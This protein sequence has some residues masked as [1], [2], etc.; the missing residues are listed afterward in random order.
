M[1]VR[2]RRAASSR[3]ASP[4]PEIEAMITGCWLMFRALTCGLTPCGR[5]TVARFCSIAARVSLTSVPYENWATT[6]EI[7]PVMRVPLPPQRIA[8]GITGGIMRSE[9]ERP[10]LDAAADHRDDFGRVEGKVCG[11]RGRGAGVGPVLGA[12]KGEVG[13][14]EQPRQDGRAAG[15][16]HPGGG[17]QQALVRLL[18]EDAPMQRLAQLW[19]PR[20][21]AT[22]MRHFCVARIS[23]IAP[24]SCTACQL[25]AAGS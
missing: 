15:D 10:R 14:R 16:Q 2:A 8:T 20:H 4:V 9:D 12:M 7:C 23:A 24:G 21:I 3:P 17:E 11:E 18:P 22:P 6:S 13:N 19:M 25:R 5:P 1:S